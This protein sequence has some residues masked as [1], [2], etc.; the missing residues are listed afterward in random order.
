MRMFQRILYLKIFL[1]LSAVFSPMLSA[2]TV[3]LS[4]VVRD[5]VTNEPIVGVAV[6]DKA[7]NHAEITGPEGDFVIN[8][9]PG[10]G[11]AF[12]FFGLP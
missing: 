9:A 10:G 12:F 1:L 11:T 2:Q 7:G 6:I 8:V 3:M 4:G 5:A